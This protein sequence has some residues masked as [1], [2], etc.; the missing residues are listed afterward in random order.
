MS[1]ATPKP[2]PPAAPICPSVPAGSC[3][4]RWF[5]ATTAPSAASRTAAACPIPVAAPVTSATLPS[6]RCSISA[7][8][9]RRSRSGST[10]TRCRREPQRQA[11]DHELEPPFL[12][13]RPGHVLQLQAVGREHAHG[14]DLQRVDRVQHALDVARD[15]LAVTIGQER[16][17]LPLVHPGDRVHVQAGLALAG[18][19]VV[20]APRAQLQ[21]APVVPGAEHE[22][23]P[24]A[25]PDSLRRLDRLQLG[26]GDRL[27]RLQPRDAA[28]PR[29]VQ[30]H[31]PADQAVVIGG[32]VEGGGAPRGH[33]LLGR[34]PVVHLALVGDVAQR[35]HV[36]VAVA[37]EGQPDV[38]GGERHPA[39]AD[40]DV[41]ALHH[42]MGDRAR[43]VRAR[44]R[45]S[46]G[47]T[48]SPAARTGPARPR[49]GRC[50]G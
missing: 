10:A 32:H 21:A 39:G 50:P 26:P 17:D 5:T 25:E 14:G 12:L 33:H 36:S 34:A 41:V 44:P 29:H 43:V 1:A 30:Q 28:E 3:P 23:V 24:L 49:P 48:S 18:R 40:V 38:V 19:R 7:A 4:G 6:K 46:S 22:D 15:R 37:V 16:G 8:P 13:A 20:V 11:D 42:V 47:S 27:T 31:A 35:V 45:C 2:L 9:L